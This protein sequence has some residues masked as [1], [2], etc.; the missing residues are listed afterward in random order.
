MNEGGA[1]EKLHLGS[2][3]DAITV[4]FMRGTFGV[5]IRSFAILTAGGEAQTAPPFGRFG[6]LSNAPPFDCP[7]SL[8]G[9]FTYILMHLKYAPKL[10][11]CQ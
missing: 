1:A 11:A 3:V 9:T 8:A 2:F 4:R 6:G 7:A 10:D 5:Q